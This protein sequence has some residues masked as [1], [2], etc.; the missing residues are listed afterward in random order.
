MADLSVDFWDELFVTDPA[1]WTN[2]AI[3]QTLLKHLGSLTDTSAKMDVLIPMCGKS[4][5]MMSLLDRG[6][7]VV[8]IEWSEARIQ[9]FFEENSLK[10]TITVSKINNTD[11]PVYKAIEKP[12]SLYC[13]DIFLFNSSNMTPDSFDCVL[14]HGVPGFFDYSEEKRREY[15][16]MICSLMKPGGRVL[17]SFFDYDHSEHPNIPFAITKEEVSVL[18]EHSFKKEILQNLNAR[19]TMEHFRILEDSV[20]HVFPI[21]TFKHF[22]WRVALLSKK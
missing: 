3:D 8:G 11:V 18:Y 12:I 9:Q 22:H 21:W 14:D 4:G 1:L 2:T 17:F 19:E 7:H 20:K 15:A 6:H 16:K 10:Y 13:G 5:V